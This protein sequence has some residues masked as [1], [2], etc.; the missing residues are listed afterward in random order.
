M[1]FSF[2][3]EIATFHDM[4][5]PFHVAFPS[6]VTLYARTYIYVR[7]HVCTYAITKDL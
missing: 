3:K 1:H 4:R 6:P 7:M 2:R 5:G